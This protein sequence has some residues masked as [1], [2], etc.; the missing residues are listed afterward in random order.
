MLTGVLHCR[1]VTR[2]CAVQ[3]TRPASYVQVMTAVMVILVTRGI[4]QRPCLLCTEHAANSWFGREEPIAAAP[5]LSAARL[6]LQQ[7]PAPAHTAAA[8]TARSG[9]DG[10]ATSVHHLRSLQPEVINQFGSPVSLQPRSPPA[11]SPVLAARPR[12][13]V[14]TSE[15][16]A[17][18]QRRAPAAAARGSPD[19]ARTHVHEGRTSQVANAILS[20]AGSGGGALVESTPPGSDASDG[21]DGGLLEGLSAPG[22][23]VDDLLARFAPLLLYALVYGPF[24][25]WNILDTE[26]RACRLQTAKTKG[27]QLQKE[28]V[29]MYTAHRQAELRAQALSQQLAATEERADQLSGRA[30]S[31]ADLPKRNNNLQ[32][33]LASLSMVLQQS[34]GAAAAAEMR[35]SKLE[36]QVRAFDIP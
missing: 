10:S 24:F 7:Q 11:A 17:A 26:C 27:V 29:G 2:C 33:E 25:V 12:P 30:N 21:V 9:T 34:R 1:V 23:S 28:M 18:T 31:M 6:A 15:I 13:P 8:N 4:Q 20:T 36:A 14:S 5:P 35:S 16:T 22:T 32:L 19:E 3:S